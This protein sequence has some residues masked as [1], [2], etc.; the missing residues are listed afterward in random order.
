[1][2]EPAV[3][4][5]RVQVH[6]H[7]LLE[8]NIWGLFFYVCEIEEEYRENNT[9][10]RDIHLYAFLGRLLVFLKHAQESYRAIG[11]N[12]T[13]EVRVVLE[14]MRGTTFLYSPHSSF[15]EEGSNSQLDDTI[16]FVLSVPSSSLQINPDA[17]AA[18]ILRILFFA[19]NLPLMVNPDE[20]INALIKSGYQYNCWT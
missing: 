10:S 8:A 3:F 1:M 17:I 12:G 7:S 5:R 11:Y 18:D 2:G 4:I 19:V 13:L 6:G 9:K 20:E 15:S 14:K 16:S